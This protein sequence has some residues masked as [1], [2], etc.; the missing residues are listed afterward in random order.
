MYADQEQPVL[1]ATVLQLQV[2]FER[3][4]VVAQVEPARWAQTRQQPLPGWRRSVCPLCIHRSASPTPQ[5]IKKPL[6][7]LQG[8]E[9]LVVPPLFATRSTGGLRSG[10]ASCARW[11]M[12]A[13]GL[14]NGALSDSA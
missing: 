9:A 5:Q 1:P 13:L 7:R 10:A 2:F 12:Y 6:A 11:R 14:A 3:P 8:R 4:H